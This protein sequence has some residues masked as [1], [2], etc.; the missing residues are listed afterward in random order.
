MVEFMKTEFKD[1]MS[2]LEIYLLFLIFSVFS[3]EIN[4]QEVW[5]PSLIFLTER[6]IFFLRIKKKS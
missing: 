4:I 6:V 2:C 1:I 3:H 5:V